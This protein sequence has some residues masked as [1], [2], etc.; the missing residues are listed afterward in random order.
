MFR[1]LRNINP[2]T[3]SAKESRSAGTLYSPAMVSYF[4]TE[5]HISPDSAIRIS[6]VWRAVSIL[7][8]TI[9]SLPLHVY[10][11][12]ENGDRTKAKTHPLYFLLHSQPHTLYTKYNFF[13]SLIT[14]L[15]LNGNAYALILRDADTMPT[16]LLLLENEKVTV[17]FDELTNTIYYRVMGYS[18]TFFSDDMIHVAGLGAKGYL[19]M[20]KLAVHGKTL[21]GARD[22]RD[23]AVNFFANGASPSGVLEYD[24]E[25]SDDAFERLKGSWQAQ[26]GGVANAGKTPLLEFGVKYKKIGATPAEAGLKDNRTYSLEDISRIFGVPMHLLSNLERATFNNIE[27]LTLQFV[28]LTVIQLCTRIEQELERKLFLRRSELETFTIN[29]NM[30]GLLRG[31]TKSRSEYYRTMFS[32]GAISINEIRQKENM[33]RVEGGDTHYRPL[34][35]EDITQI[36]ED[37]TGKEKGEAKTDISKTK[38]QGSNE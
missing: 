14:N 2:F 11:E 28:K 26:Y 36:G 19:G 20:N 25:L 16:G 38:T 6:G 34:N 18:Q 37:E 23:Y 15:A 9:A 4:Q 22:L 7:A 24:S 3:R 10:R 17:Y 5:E 35:M 1:W 21:N 12:A 32:I 30:E 8:E 13:E 33:N 27:H 31:D 29:F